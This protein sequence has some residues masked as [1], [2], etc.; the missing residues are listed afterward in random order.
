MYYLI[1]KFTQIFICGV[2]V[3]LVV[4]CAAPSHH[5]CVPYVATGTIH[6]SSALISGPRAAHGFSVSNRLMYMATLSAFRYNIVRWSLKF[7]G[8]SRYTTSHRIW[9]TESINP[10]QRTEFVR[11]FLKKKTL[12]TIQYILGTFFSHS[13]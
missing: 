8:G 11:I 4:G 7:E 6:E 5:T 10:L 2:T 3:I 9:S 1:S 13:L 12:S